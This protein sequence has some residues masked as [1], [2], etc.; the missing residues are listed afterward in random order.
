MK[1]S[2]RSKGLGFDFFYSDG[3]VRQTIFHLHLLGY[4][5]LSTESS[6]DDACCLKSSSFAS[7]LITRS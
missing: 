6:S 3:E 5:K 1:T 4:E 7:L 2:S